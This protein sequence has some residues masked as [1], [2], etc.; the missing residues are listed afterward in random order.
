MRP[1]LTLNTMIHIKDKVEQS[2]EMNSA[3]PLHIGEVANEK[4]DF[5]SQLTTMAN[6]IFIKKIEIQSNPKVY[7]NGKSSLK[8]T[9]Q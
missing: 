9:N 7:Y 1:Y 3:P 4:G 6:L 2:T 8:F 5:V